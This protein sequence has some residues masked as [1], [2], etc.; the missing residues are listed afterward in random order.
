VRGGRDVVIADS[1]LGPSGGRGAAF[2]GAK[3]SG[4]MRSDFSGSGAEAVVL[5]GGD[6]RSLTPGSLF[7]RD[8]RLTRY[9]R[10][11][12]TQHPAVAL[13]GVGAEVAGNL[14]HDSP[15]YAVH[16][17]G[18]DHRITGN[19]I[20]TLLA[21]ATDTGAIYAGRDWTA[22]GSV[23][24]GNFLHD[25][26]GDAEHE[27]KG[28]YLDDMASGFTVAGNLFLRVDQP[29][30]LGGG[31]DNRVEGNVLV[32]SSPALH[33]DSRGQT[34]AR[35][36]IEDPQSEL[37]AAYAAMPVESGPWRARYP[38]L[39]GLLTNRPGVATGNVVT[40]NLLALSEPFRFTDGGAQAEQ[41]LAR[42]RGPA[43]PPENLADLAMTSVKPEDFAALAD[44]TGLRLPTIPSAR[45]R[46]S[47]LA[48][49]PFGR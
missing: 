13:D 24:S 44:G 17:R 4:V 36:A 10:R 40:D 37:R 7:L 45:M 19:E 46:R 43:R 28:V 39:P 32:A 18:N 9:A 25:I 33:V 47:G 12:P 2:S 35:D 34:W 6:R 20:A 49:A 48:G 5:S 16:I 27:V 3:D 14:I 8:S 15:A 11:R 29:I 21:G 41:T 26:R 30:F 22:R 38:G 1:V 42:N 23:I 31:R